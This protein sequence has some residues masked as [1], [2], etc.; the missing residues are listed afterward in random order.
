MKLTTRL[1]A[2]FLILAMWLS[3]TGCG[4]TGTIDTDGSASSTAATTTATAAEDTPSTTTGEQGAT[5]TS[6]ESMVGQTT[7][8][9]TSAPIPTKPTASVITTSKPATTT[10]TGRPSATTSAH[11][12]STTEQLLVDAAFLLME[13]E[14]LQGDVALTGTVTYVKEISEGYGNAT[15][16]LQVYGSDGPKTIYCYRAKPADGTPLAVAVGDELRLNGTVQN[17]KGT[18]EFYPATYT[19]LSGG[20]PIATTTRPTVRPTTGGAAIAEDGI[21]E[22]KE[23]VALYIHTYGKLPKNFVTKSE[24]NSLGKPA[25]KCCGGDRFYNKEGLL[26]NKAGRLYYECD[27]DTYGITSRGAKRIVYSNDGLIY[28]TGDHYK[29]FTLLYGEP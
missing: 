11:S 9:A 16:D 22:S 29:S 17:Y 7:T 27:I 3:L 10:T 4:A 8:S 25:N 1:L 18:I 6:A 15:F 14:S 21:Y 24:Y 23:D 26:P 2:L 13:D 5:T 19:R 12:T 28:Y 20:V